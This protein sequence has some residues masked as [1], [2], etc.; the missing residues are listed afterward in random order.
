MIAIRTAASGALSLKRTPSPLGSIPNCFHNASRSTG[1][2]AFAH[3]TVEFCQ[4]MRAGRLIADGE[5]LFDRPVLIDR[6][7]AATIARRAS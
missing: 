2:G 5:R 6:S 7:P 1:F 4:N 3:L